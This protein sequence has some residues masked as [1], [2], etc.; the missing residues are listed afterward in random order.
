MSYLLSQYVQGTFTPWEWTSGDVP[1]SFCGDRYVPD[2]IYWHLEKE[3]N[4]V[5]ADLE[6]VNH[7]TPW[8]SGEPESEKMRA[9][10][11]C[12]MID[13]VVECVGKYY[14]SGGDY[15]H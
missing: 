5:L 1:E 7:W 13:L 6:C 15:G 14:R 11:C 2:D 3:T 8:V 9:D 12:G 4:R 10:A